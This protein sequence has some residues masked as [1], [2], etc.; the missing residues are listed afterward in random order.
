MCTEVVSHFTADVNKL[1]V[2]LLLS[3]SRL[4]YIRI[5]I[6]CVCAQQMRA[7]SPAFDCDVLRSLVKQC[8]LM[9]NSVITHVQTDVLQHQ[10]AVSEVK[11]YS[12]HLTDT[13]PSQSRLQQSS[14]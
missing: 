14:R 7:V 1:C 6:E 8:K 5:Y 3:V 4:M 2:A 13:C 11:Q 12:P 9:Q 10:F